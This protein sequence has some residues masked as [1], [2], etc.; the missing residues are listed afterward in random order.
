MTSRERLLAIF[1]QQ[2]YDRL[3]IWIMLPY[4]YETEGMDYNLEESYQEVVSFARK[5]TDFIDRTGIN[6]GDIT[7]ELLF[8]HPK[9]SRFLEKQ[10]DGSERYCIQCG[11]IKLSKGIKGAMKW[12]SGSTNVSDNYITDVSQ[13]A[14][15]MRLPYE[16]PI[17]D[18]IRYKEK[19]NPVGDA[20]L[21]CVIFEDT[22]SM[23]HNIV[24]EEDACVFA[25]M[26]TKEVKKFLDFLLP[27]QL[28]YYEQFLTVGAGDVFF[29]SGAEYLTSP[30][31][32]PRVFRELITPYN[33]AIVELIH[34]YGKHA[35]LHC[36]GNV[37]DILGEIKE[38][39][40]DALHPVEPK[41]MGDAE[42]VDVRK[43]LGD[44]II[45]IGNIEYSDLAEKT[46]DEIN[47]LVK[48]LIKETGNKN[49]IL[50]PSCSMYE[51]RISKKQSDNYI[52][53]MQA[54][55]EYGKK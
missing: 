7:S 52:A 47:S 10:A 49:L 50:S 51:P 24:S 26:E 27:R 9:I 18:M 20:G 30:L 53:F 33:K 35:I 44:E 31:G 2:N 14:D 17:I 25:A 45:L 42:I 8:H 43:A 22:F 21:T 12:V 23:F 4:T 40:A 1:R 37:R 3:P 39:G 16:M 29:I 54:G 28:K 36:H 34:S 15:I 13:L 6:R 46:Q 5:Y 48:T 55:L 11:H 19:M 32:S 38:I 41:P